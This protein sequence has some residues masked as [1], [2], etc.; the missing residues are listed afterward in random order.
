[1]AAFSEL[2]IQGPA[3]GQLYHMI[4]FKGRRAHHTVAVIDGNHQLLKVPLGIVLP[5]AVGTTHQLK[6]GP[7]RCIFHRYRQVLGQEEYLHSKEH[8]TQ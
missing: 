3:T 2:S 5:N 1:M 4:R 8:S 7:P 6:Q